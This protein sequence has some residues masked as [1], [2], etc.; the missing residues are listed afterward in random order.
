MSV[1]AKELIAEATE[2]RKRKLYEPVLVR[3]FQTYDADESGALEADEVRQIMLDCIEDERKVLTKDEVTQFMRVIGGEDA[4]EIN[5]EELTISQDN[6][7]QFIMS[8]I[9]KNK[10]QLSKF[11]KRSP[12]H[13]KLY[14]FMVHLM[15]DGDA[16]ERAEYQRN[17]ASYKWFV[18]MIWRKYDKDKSGAIDVDEMKE[19]LADAVKPTLEKTAQS[20][21]LVGGGSSR[22]AAHLPTRQ[23]TAAFMKSL[24]KNRNG[25]LDK[26][27]FSKFGGGF[28]GSPKMSSP[29]LGPTLYRTRR[30]KND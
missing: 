5:D 28:R 15:A 1:S 30:H 9:L 11:A 13:K 25:S 6:F 2:A 14:V 27:E 19:L 21:D 26:A 23:E 7:V 4:N 22:L 17:E 24:D 18:N 3:L 20:A 16:L 8:G 12:M 10:K 29:T